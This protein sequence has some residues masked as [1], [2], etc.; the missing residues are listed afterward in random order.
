MRPLMVAALVLWTAFPACA[1]EIPRPSLADKN[2]STIACEVVI[3]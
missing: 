1:E 2:C 3:K